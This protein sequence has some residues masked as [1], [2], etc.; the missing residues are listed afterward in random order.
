MGRGHDTAPHCPGQ[1]LLAGGAK[2]LAD[3]ELLALLLQRGRAGVPALALASELMAQ[4]GGLAGVVEAEPAQ[5]LAWPGVGTGKYA[6][7]RAALELARRHALRRIEGVDILSSPA[8]T[9]RFLQHHLGNQ[10]R[11]IFCC[12][13]LN[14][15]HHVL[16]CDD[17]FYGTLDGAAVYPREVAV[18]A[19]QYRA[20]AVILAHNHPSGVPEPSSADRRITERL[21]AALG[22]LDIRVL[23]HIVVGSGQALSFA[24]QG[25]L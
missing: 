8:S 14:N 2:T 11:E 23:D 20:A 13:F 25:L 9:K 3:A 1:R 22:L 19:L 21:V 17:L 24:E 15:Q 7:L 5:L 6:A 12:L 16:R 10:P 18:R 4:F